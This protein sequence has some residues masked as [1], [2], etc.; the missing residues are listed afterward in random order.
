M[1]ANRHKELNNESIAL[2]L[3][4]VTML[5]FSVDDYNKL[6]E[7]EDE[8]RQEMLSQEPRVSFFSRVLQYLH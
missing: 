2:S 7:L 6:K 3:P 4:R 8:L 5:C 1:K